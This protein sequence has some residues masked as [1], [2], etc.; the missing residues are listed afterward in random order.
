MKEMMQKLRDASLD[1]VQITFYS[2]KEEIHNRL[3]GA[4]QS[5]KL[6]VIVDH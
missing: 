2:E 5:A 6:P 4:D 1:S 3:V